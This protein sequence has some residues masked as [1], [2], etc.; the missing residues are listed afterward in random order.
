LWDETLENFCK[1]IKNNY[2]DMKIF[3]G[4]GV[5][6]MFQSNLIDYYIQG[7]GEYAVLELLKYIYGNGPRPKF[8]LDLSDKR[9]IINANDTYPAY[10]MKS[11]LVKYQD[12][13]FIEPDEW[14]TIEFSRGCKFACDFCNFPIIGVKGDYTRDADDFELQMRDTYDRFGVQNYLVADETFNDRTEKITKFA[15]VV[16]R[17]PFDPWFSGFIRADLLIAR[18]EDRE[19][20]LRMN[21]LGHYYG[22]ESFNHDSAKA[23][24]K[25]MKTDRLQAGLVDIKKY[26]MN[27]GNNQYRG[28]IS[29]ILGLPFDTY[30]TIEQT[31]QWLISHWQTQAFSAWQLEIHQGKLDKLSKIDTDYK[32]YGYEQM[33]PTEIPMDWNSGPG[34]N[35]SNSLLYWKNKNLDYFSVSN[36]IKEFIVAKKEYDFR[37][38]PF[39]LAYRFAKKLSLNDTLALGSDFL[40]LS[41]EHVE[42]YKT[43]KLS[44]AAH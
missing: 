19:E 2:E 37:L 22:I 29:L 3:S 24:G 39:N 25:G 28:S 10:P 31:K 11:L 20:L 12:R 7:F 6:P 18:K 23:V 41:L 15:N 43:K 35:L 17:L 42:K 36:L 9:K 32:S 16:E 34:P 38:S 44:W 33:L 21:F 40:D 1:W 4:S 30:E 13:D 5:N 26:F 27:H 8:R 14:L